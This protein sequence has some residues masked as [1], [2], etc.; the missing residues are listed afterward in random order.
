MYTANTMASAV[1]ALGM[2]LP[3]S[4]STPA[5]DPLKRAECLFAGE[6]ILNLMKKDIKPRYE[7]T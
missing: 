7:S 4:S 3:L 5:D 2:S 6:A 1:E